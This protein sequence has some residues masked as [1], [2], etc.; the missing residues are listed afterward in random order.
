MRPDSK[1]FKKMIIKDVFK[2]KF[3]KF[4]YKKRLCIKVN[5]TEQ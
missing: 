1:W 2:F 5:N 4:Y 3:K